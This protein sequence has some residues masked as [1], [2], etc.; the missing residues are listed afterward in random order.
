MKIR[1]Y[2]MWAYWLYFVVWTPL[3]RNRLDILR[4][5][6]EWMQDWLDKNEVK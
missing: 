5:Q 6:I 1:F 2:H 4:K 3:L